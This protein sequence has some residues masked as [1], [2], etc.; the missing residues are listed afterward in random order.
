MTEE[1]IPFDLVRMFIGKDSTLLLLEIL[2]RSVVIYLYTFALL[3]W[4]GGRS[5]AQF[6]LIE[7]LLVIA[8]GSAVGD[9][10]FYPEVPLLHAMLVVTVIVLIN[11]GLDLLML[12]KDAVKS[13]IDGQPVEVVRDGQINIVGLVERSMSM[14][15]LFEQ[16]RIRGVE[17]LDQVRYAYIEPSGNLSL[18]LDTGAN[19]GVGIVPPFNIGA[20]TEDFVAAP[21]GRIFNCQCCG[22]DRDAKSL[23]TQAHCQDCSKSI[24]LPII[25]DRR[26]A[27]W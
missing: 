21:D 26:T 16:L 25:R 23:R 9:A 1:T 10:M 24:W 8:L 17:T 27:D 19:T 22:S 18:F 6:S 13:V 2:F 11:K 15:E 7:F 5:V 3:R 20:T 12:H 4:I 14:K